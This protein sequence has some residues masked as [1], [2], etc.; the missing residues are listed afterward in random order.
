MRTLLHPDPASLADYDK[1]IRLNPNYVEAYFHR[2]CLKDYLALRE[3]LVSDRNAG[4][5]S[6]IS[7]LDEVIRL[8]PN[9]PYLS[10]T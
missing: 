5:R 3:S 9:F 10:D 7:D 1:A 8:D 4:L 6:T 2:A